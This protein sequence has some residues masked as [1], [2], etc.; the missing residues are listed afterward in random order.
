MKNQIRFFCGIFFLLSVF[1]VTSSFTNTSANFISDFTKVIYKISPESKLEVFGETNI[2]SFCCTSNETFKTQYLKYKFDQDQSIIFF[3][4]AKLKIEVEQ[5]NCGKRPINRDLYKALKTDEFPYIIINIK[6]IFNSKCDD[7]T[8]CD[9]W[10]EFEADLD[11]TITC[12]T[13]SVR[14]PLLGKK[15]DTQ[16]F[17]ITGGTSLDLCDFDI[18]APTALLGLIQVEDNIDLNFDLFIDME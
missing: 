4:D 14:I 7:L 16:S 13:Q 6:E 15:L 17:R 8:D 11:I 10:V 12:E 1:A 18:E 9:K 5:L 3:Q 2:N